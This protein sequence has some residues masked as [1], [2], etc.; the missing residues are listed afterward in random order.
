MPLGKERTS[1][2]VRLR[3]EP[4]IGAAGSDTACLPAANH[5]LGLTETGTADTNLRL[6][7]LVNHDL[8]RRVTAV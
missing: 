3:E 6:F 1:S 4:I 5:E 8:D 2:Q 7:V